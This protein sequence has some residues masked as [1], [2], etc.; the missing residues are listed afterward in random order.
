MK[1]L[2][3]L[4]VLLLTACEMDAEP[5]TVLDQCLRADLFKQCLAQVP[6][7]PVSTVENPWHKVVEECESAAYHQS[8]RKTGM[9][10]MKCRSQ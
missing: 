2:T 9:V 4:L 10:E 8:W 1:L 7:G 6:K 5:T 3:V